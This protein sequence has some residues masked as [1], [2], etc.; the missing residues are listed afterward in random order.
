MTVC[1]DEP[2]IQLSLNSTVARDSKYKFTPWR[3]LSNV[4]RPSTLA[5]ELSNPDPC[6]ILKLTTER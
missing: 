1:Y 3:G 5:F 2:K 4:H 6:S